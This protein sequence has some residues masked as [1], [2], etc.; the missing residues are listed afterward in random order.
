MP[1]PLTHS[2]L[3]SGPPRPFPWFCPN[4]RRKEVRRATIPYQCELDCNGQRVTV[5]LANL[6]VPR[7]DNCGELVFDYEAD[8]QINRAF[9]L[10]TRALSSGPGSNGTA[11]ALNGAPT[12]ERLKASPAAERPKGLAEEVTGALPPEIL[13]ALAQKL[14]ANGSSS[15]PQ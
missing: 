13:A 5:V 12:E 8:E 6:A 4:C 3:A 1:E 14:K 11:R 9:E 7:C 10:Q 15:K 2:G